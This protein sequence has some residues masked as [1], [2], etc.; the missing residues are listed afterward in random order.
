[1]NPLKD[2]PVI[3]LGS[4][5]HAKVV[6]DLLLENGF[7]VCGMTTADLLCFGNLF[8]AGFPF[9]ETTKSSHHILRRAMSLPAGS[10]PLEYRQ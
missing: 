7:T 8:G 4:G 1:M 9:W 5:G 6:L 3:L 10:A 2:M